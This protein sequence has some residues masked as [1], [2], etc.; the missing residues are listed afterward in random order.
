MLRV[1]RV[2]NALFLY[3]HLNCK[4]RQKKSGESQSRGLRISGRINILRKMFF[5][6]LQKNNIDGD[7]I[8]HIIHNGAFII[9]CQWQF[10][11]RR[12]LSSFFS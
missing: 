11:L 10:T 8:S 12:E 1:I 9:H 7:E 5:M 4:K 2:F 3:H 6:R